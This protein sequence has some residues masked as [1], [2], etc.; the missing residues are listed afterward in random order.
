MSLWSTKYRI[1]I[2]HIHEQQIHKTAYAKYII[3][4]MQYH[5][6]CYAFNNLKRNT[7][8][9]SSICTFLNFISQISSFPSS[10]P[11]I[12]GGKLSGPLGPTLGLFKMLA[13]DSPFFSL[14]I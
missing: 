4:R 7:N 11:S 13:T 1:F 5:R 10:I 8:V 2:R 3:Q 6:D 14:T 12:L 9:L